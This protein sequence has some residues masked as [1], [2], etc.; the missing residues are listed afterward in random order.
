MRKKRTRLKVLERRRIENPTGQTA[1]VTFSSKKQKTVTMSASVK[2][3]ASYGA[4][5]ASV[6][7]EVDAGVEK[8]YTNEIG[9]SV[10]YKVPSGRA[11]MGRYGT[12]IRPVTGRLKKGDGA[13]NCV[14]DRRITAYL[15]KAS[16]WRIGIEKL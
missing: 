15:P 3:K 6:E 1:K 12:F 11:A 13:N 14:F 8:S 7:A 16:G 9:E 5:F 4:I 2:V 10:E